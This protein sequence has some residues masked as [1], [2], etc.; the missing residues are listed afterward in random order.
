MSDEDAEIEQWKKLT[1]T[2][3]RVNTVSQTLSKPRSAQYIAQEAAVPENDARD[4]L[5]RLVERGALR[6]YSE[7]G[8][9][10]YGPDPSYTR[11]QDVRELIDSYNDEAL[12]SLRADLRE[13]IESWQST[14]GVDSPEK[15]EGLTDRREDRGEAAQKRKI[16]AA[17][18]LSEY[19]LNLVEEALEV[20]DNSDD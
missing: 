1:T 15:I 13:Q 2:F 12:R 10:L 7:S 3:E 6:Q 16:A 20:S 19:R 4:H 9:T 5:N 11:E 17:W 14:C 8:S 18:A